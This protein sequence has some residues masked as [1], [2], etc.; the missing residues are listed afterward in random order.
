MAGM[1]GRFEHKIFQTAL[2]SF[3]VHLVRS[4]TRT[5]TVVAV[6]CLNSG[7]LLLLG[8]GLGLVTHGHVSHAFRRVSQ[9]FLSP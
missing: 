9:S 4:Y 5:I 2:L 6:L 8:H 3:F 7:T 1:A